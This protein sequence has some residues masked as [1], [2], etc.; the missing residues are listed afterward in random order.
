MFRHRIG[1]PSRLNVAE[2]KVCLSRNLQVWHY[3]AE[4]GDAP[5]WYPASTLAASAS[6]APAARHSTAIPPQA[7]N[8]PVLQVET[9]TGGCSQQPKTWTGGL[10]SKAVWWDARR[11]KT[12]MDA[13]VFFFLFSALRRRNGTKKK[14]VGILR[15]RPLPLGVS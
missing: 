1:N 13:L 8:D 2:M 9:H 5:G 12:P 6:H 4:C 3:R 10:I 7:A 14:T 15:W 11:M